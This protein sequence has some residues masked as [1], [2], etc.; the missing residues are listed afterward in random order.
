MLTSIYSI[1][2][3]YSNAVNLK[4]LQNSLF[5]PAINEAGAGVLGLDCGVIAQANK[6]G[7]E[8]AFAREG[9]VLSE[10]VSE[11]TARE[12]LGRTRLEDS[13]QALEGDLLGSELF[14]G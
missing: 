4:L 11:L 12:P 7:F 8:V 10:E 13:E 2:Y 14:G 3:R 1:I 6:G 9:L 5:F